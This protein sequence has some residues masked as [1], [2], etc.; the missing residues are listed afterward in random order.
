MILK[1]LI[2]L[3]RIVW[4]LVWEMEIV[5]A[6]KSLKLSSNLLELRCVSFGFAGD[7]TF[8]SSQL[9]ESYVEIDGKDVSLKGSRYTKQDA[10]SILCKVWMQFES[11]ESFFICF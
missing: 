4:V 3:N 10:S 5:V 9:A 11:F 6:F 1:F 7:I 8:Q 2:S